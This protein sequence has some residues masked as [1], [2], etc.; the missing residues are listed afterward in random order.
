[1]SVFDRSKPV[2][3]EIQVAAGDSPVT[4]FSSNSM[5]KK[6]MLSMTISFYYL[7]NQEEKFQPNVDDSKKVS[8]EL[9]SYYHRW[10]R[11]MW[12]KNELG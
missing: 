3:S 5:V 12:Q 10:K 4:L 6:T 8:L 7:E 2:I 11:K 9:I 1:M